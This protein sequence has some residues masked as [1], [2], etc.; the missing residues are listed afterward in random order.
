MVVKARERVVKTEEVGMSNGVKNRQGEWV[1]V[2]DPFVRIAHWLLAALV[3][4]AFITEGEV[5]PLHAWLGY[6]VLALIAL[7]IVWGFTGTRHARFRDFVR[8]P[9]AVLGDLWLTLTLRPRRALGHDPA[10]GAMIL[11]FLTVLVVT[12]VLGTVLLAAE[13]GIGPLAFWFAGMSEA[14][15][16]WVEE[17]H[18]F[19]A[20]TAIVLAV[21]HVVAVIFVSLTRRENLIR[22]MITGWKRRDIE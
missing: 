11:I 21:L 16:E 9:S 3:I 6:A 1:R 15:E 13:D 22:S 7:R 5:M 17:L 10:G 4:A 12:G 19:F 18:E 8:G 14:G 20:N 2:W